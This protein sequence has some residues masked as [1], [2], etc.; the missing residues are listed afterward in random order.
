LGLYCSPYT[1]QQ[2]CSCL[3]IYCRTVLTRPGS[4]RTFVSFLRWCQR[5]GECWS[6]RVKLYYVRLLPLRQRIGTLTIWC[7]DAAY[8]GVLR[9]QDLDRK[10]PVTGFDHRIKIQVQFALLW[11]LYSPPLI[12]TVYVFVFF[13]V[14]VLRYA[15][16]HRD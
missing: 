2:G 7:L 11:S 8:L 6:P 3:Y 14:N 13:L 5:V 4:Y 10:N 15:P 16:S 9:P 12:A 1:V